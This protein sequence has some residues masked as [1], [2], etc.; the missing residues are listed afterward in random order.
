M[1]YNT[2]DT[3]FN[4][5]GPATAG[6]MT[7][8]REALGR[9]QEMLSQLSTLSALAKE[10]QAY[11][12]NEKMNPLLV[13]NQGLV[14]Q[15]L[16]AGLPGITADSARKGVDARVAAG[17]ELSTIASGNSS[18]QTKILGNQLHDAQA[19]AEL[20]QQLSQVLMQTPAPA[21]HSVAMQWMDQHGVSNNPAF[22][23]YKDMVLNTS[24]VQMPQRLASMSQSIRDWSNQNQNQYLVEAMKMAGHERI[25]AAANASH[26]RVA[27]TMADSRIELAA[28][29]AA[30][31]PQLA[32]LTPQA[33]SQV[34]SGALATGIDPIT[35]KPM[36]NE[37]K[38][39]Y[40]AMYI[41]AVANQDVKVPNAPAQLQD[42]Q[43]VNPA[44][45]STNTNPGKQEEGGRTTSG[46]TYKFVK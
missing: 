1:P 31:P 16:E 7:G 18:N 23:P 35:K 20:T 44:K 17:T 33:L 6:Y 21:R 38:I 41:Q 25:G 13:Q 5:L 15:G 14:N 28:N 30:V 36:T 39:G 10:S 45:P 11:G 40:Q 22:A 37:D 4:N 19:A 9:Q 46:V 26:E 29:K 42:G 27:K 3:L 2:L 24:P 8:Q 32:K 34:L 43:I 12:Q